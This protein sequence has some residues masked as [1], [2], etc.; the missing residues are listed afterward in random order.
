METAKVTSKGQITIPSKLRK[1]LRL[2]PGDRVRF[3][4]S[5]DGSLR[6][7]ALRTHDEPLRGLLSDVAVGKRIDSQE[8]RRAV[9]RRAAHKHRKK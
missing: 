2:R 7:S 4:W 8:I 3:E 6:M 9:R 5:D 1:R